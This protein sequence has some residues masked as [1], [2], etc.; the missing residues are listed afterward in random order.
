MPSDPA[1]LPEAL[2]FDPTRPRALPKPER[3][4][5]LTRVEFAKLILAQDGRCACGC[6]ERLV[7]DEIIDE[8]LTPLDCLGSNKLSN[9]AL[10]RKECAAKKTQ[11]DRERRDHGRR[12]RGE[13][14]NGPKK[15]IPARQ[16]PWGR[17]RKMGHPKLVRGVDGKVRERT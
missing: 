4:R 3:R 15:P 1:P 14:H 11:K 12:V 10:Y 2:P 8:H 5:P 7:A 6:N 16:E 9:R 17:G 13:T